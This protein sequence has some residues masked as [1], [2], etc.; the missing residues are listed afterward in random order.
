MVCDVSAFDA[1]D[2]TENMFLVWGLI[3]F[4]HVFY[5][6]IRLVDCIERA[7]LNIK[8][9]GRYFYNKNSQGSIG[10]K[11][12]YVGTSCLYIAPFITGVFLF[13]ISSQIGNKI[14][15]FISLPPDLLK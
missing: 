15:D 2:V 10:G 13:V 6:A 3:I 4:L 9:I 11:T 5:Q 14:L 12:C 1:R 7:V 8:F